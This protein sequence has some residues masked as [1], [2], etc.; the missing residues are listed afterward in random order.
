MMNNHSRNFPPRRAGDPLQS[1]MATQALGKSDTREQRKA[2]TNW[3]S[4]SSLYHHRWFSGW[5]LW[6]V[7]PIELFKIDDYYLWAPVDAYFGKP[8]KPKRDMR[9]PGQIIFCANSQYA[10][11]HDAPRASLRLDICGA[12]VWLTIAIHDY[13]YNRLF[14]FP[15][16]RLH[17]WRPRRFGGWSVGA[18]QYGFS[19]PKPNRGFL[20]SDAGTSQWM[21]SGFCGIRPGEI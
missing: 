14:H 19:R 8:E 12:A 18:F 2:R 9:D 13:W 20:Y 17:H 7:H 15:H 1:T 4:A 3:Q 11:A 10:Q 21:G 5:A 6:G 16:Y